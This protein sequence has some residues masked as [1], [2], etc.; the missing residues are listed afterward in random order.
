MKN[1]FLSRFFLVTLMSLLSSCS[2]P[3]HEHVWGQWRSDATKHWRYC[4]A[5][6]CEDPRAKEE[7]EHVGY[8]C[9]ICGPSFTAVAFYTGIDDAAHVSFCHEANEWFEKTSKTHNFIY[10]STTNWD[11]LNDEYLADVDI[12]L[13]LDTRPEKP[14]Q[15]A[16]FEKYMEEGGAWIG[17]HF[18]AFALTPSSYPQ[19]WD[20]YHE[21]FLGAGQYV[22]NTWEPTSAILKVEN[23][24]YPG[25]KNIPNKFE[26]TPCEWYRWEHDLRNNP[27]IEIL[28]SIDPSSFPLG[29]GPKE[30][31]IWHSGYYPV[32]WTNIGYNMLYMNMGHNLMNYSTN[33][34]L[35]YTFS[36]DVQNTLLLDTMFGFFN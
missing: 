32:V 25:T 33:E 36:S 27:D 10:K 23:H 17:F 7:G 19:D 4:I 9:E 31:E 13:F 35:S 24:Y 30:S 1:K 34:T 12:V 18:A 20:W 6:G 8:P 11:N 21:N 14:S 3:K 5:N 2:T 16:A 26:A 29:T 22:S 15:R 28:C